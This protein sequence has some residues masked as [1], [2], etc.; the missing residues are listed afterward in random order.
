MLCAGLASSAVLAGVDSPELRAQAAGRYLEVQ[1]VSAMVE[2]VLPL[3][4]MRVRNLPEDQQQKYLSFVRK[5]VRVDLMEQKAREAL[6]KEFT[7]DELNALAALYGSKDGASAMKK[8]QYTAPLV[9]LVRTELE[10]AM[11][12]V[13][14]D[15]A[16]KKAADCS[17]EK[18]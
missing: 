9:L 16:A 11:A 18:K 8:L 7:A 13:G 12:C 3:A 17:E 14:P 6:V 2:E 5:L 15:E 1:P 4:Q 10:R